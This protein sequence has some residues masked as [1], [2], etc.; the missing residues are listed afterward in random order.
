MG[1]AL[2]LATRSSPLAVAQAEL[3]AGLLERAGYACELVKIAPAEEAGTAPASGGPGPDGGSGKSDGS[4]PTD[5]GRFVRGVEQALL[6]GRADI[7]VHSAKDLPTDLLPGLIL[8]GTPRRA[9]ATDAWVPAGAVEESVAGERQGGDAAD[10]TAPGQGEDP[11]SRIPNGARV[12]T[13]SRRRR[14]QL[15]ALRPDLTLEDLRGNVETRL[16]SLTERG[17]DGAVLATAGLLRLGMADRIAFRFAASEM[18]PAAGQ[19]ALALEVRGEDGDAAAAVAAVNDPV[20]LAELTAERALVAGLDA[21]CDTPVAARA[22]VTDNELTLDAYVGRADGADWIRDR[23]SGDP[24]D[25]AAL[26]ARVAERMLAAGADEVLG[27]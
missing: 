9:E 22:T 21:D 7:G 20:S 24:G 19:G 26:G 12:G 15:L 14:S 6:D 23:L 25:A 1:R 2:R 13:S 16:R 4:V 27:R 3:V 5:K 8:A 17:L 10:R 11:L 18:L